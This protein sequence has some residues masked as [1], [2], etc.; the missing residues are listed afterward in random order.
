MTL[1]FT[2]CWKLDVTHRIIPLSCCSNLGVYPVLHLMIFSDQATITISLNVTG[3][4]ITPRYTLRIPFTICALLSTLYYGA[5]LQILKPRRSELI[6]NC[7]VNRGAFPLPTH[8]SALQTILVCVSI[9]RNSRAGRVEDKL[10]LHVFVRGN[11]SGEATMG[12]VTRLV[13]LSRILERC[14]RVAQ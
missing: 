4:I 14:S 7:L 6:Q 9:S 11:L 10:D 5:Y 13:P 12:S 3:I 8:R 2:V 1:N